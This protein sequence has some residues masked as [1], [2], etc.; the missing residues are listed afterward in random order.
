MVV[1]EK[2]QVGILFV[3]IITQIDLIW[4]KV[5][6]WMHASFFLIEFQCSVYFKMYAENEPLSL[7]VF[8][9]WQV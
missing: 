7:H 5:A 3:F 8:Y 1:L 6:F 9:F 2:D 4:I